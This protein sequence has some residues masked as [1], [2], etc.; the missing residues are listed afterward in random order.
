MTASRTVFGPLRVYID[1]PRLPPKELLAN[2]DQ[3]KQ[4]SLA[5]GLQEWQD[6][7]LTATTAS[8]PPRMIA[9]EEIPLRHLWVVREADV[10]NAQ[11]Q[12]EFGNKLES[13]VIKHTNLTGGEAAFSGGEV[14]FIDDCTIVI[15]G[16]SGRYG[17][18]S[19][20]EMDLVAQAFSKTGYHVWSMGFD[21]EV[22]KP[23]P[24]VGAL[25]KVVV[26]T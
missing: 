25:P 4:M 23:L 12:C 17:P 15:N 24:F 2:A 3:L 1:K 9:P 20:A 14:I 16:C 26:T 7:P 19:E 22:N 8:S 10:V 11:E 13:K 6:G 21:T 5:D 18:K